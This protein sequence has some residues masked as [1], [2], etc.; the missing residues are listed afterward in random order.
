[1][2]H[3][4]NSQ[5]FCQSVQPL[6]LLT[7]THDASACHMS[8]TVTTRRKLRHFYFIM[9]SPVTRIGIMLCPPR[10]FVRPFVRTDLVTTISHE[11]GLNN[12]D[13]TDREYSLYRTDDLFRF[14]GQRSRS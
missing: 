5:S 7:F 3:A 6:L 4:F 11:N 9:L 13:K 14:W 1:M 2:V 10:S 8:K 12:F